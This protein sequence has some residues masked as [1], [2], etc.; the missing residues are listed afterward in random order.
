MMGLLFTLTMGLAFLGIG[1]FAV[2]GI[3]D[4]DVRNLLWGSLMFCRWN[5]VA[6]MSAVAA[7]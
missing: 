2:Y 7:V 3:S 1:L 5:H 6:M 4:N